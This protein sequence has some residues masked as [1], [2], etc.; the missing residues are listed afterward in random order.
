MQTKLFSLSV[1][2]DWNFSLFHRQIYHKGSLDL[3][4]WAQSHMDHFYDMFM[5]LLHPYLN[6]ETSALINC[7]CTGEEITKLEL[8]SKCSILCFREEMHS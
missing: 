8:S 7:N 2:Q 4:Y 1:N 6:L 5:V 3:K